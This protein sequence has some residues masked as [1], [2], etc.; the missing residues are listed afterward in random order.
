MANKVWFSLSCSR[1]LRGALK[2]GS[3]A[4]R[5]HWMVDKDLVTLFF[6]LLVNKTIWKP[7]VFVFLRQQNQ[8]KAFRWVKPVFKTLVIFGFS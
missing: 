3:L 2:F 7:V 4:C 1:D 8:E 5:V 6:S